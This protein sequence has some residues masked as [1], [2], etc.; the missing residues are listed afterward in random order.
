M[1]ARDSRRLVVLILFSGFL[2]ALP[3]AAHDAQ[4]GA[5]CV[6]VVP[7]L[8]VAARPRF[9][10]GARLCWVGVFFL[11]ECIVR[12]AWVAARCVGRGVLPRGLE[13]PGLAAL[14]FAV[15]LFLAAQAFLA[16]H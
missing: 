7:R 15:L 5:L 10:S 6:A 2:H 12:G 14:A 1:A 4:H 16:V 11:Y 13:G 3:V 8:L 9:F